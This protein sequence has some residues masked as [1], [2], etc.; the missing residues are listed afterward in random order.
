MQNGTAI[1]RKTNEGVHAVIFDQE[2]I[3]FATQNAKVKARQDKAATNRSK[4]ARRAAH[5]RR[6]LDKLANQCMRLAIGLAA[7]SA[8][9]FFGLVNWILATVVVAAGLIVIGIK[10]GRLLEWR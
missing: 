2:T 1:I 8:L 5:K 10:I 3:E 6:V 4:V 7:L 9:A